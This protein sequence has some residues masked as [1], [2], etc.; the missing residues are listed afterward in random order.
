[1][2]LAQIAFALRFFNMTEDEEAAQI[3]APYGCREG[4]RSIPKPVRVTD[5]L[6]IFEDGSSFARLF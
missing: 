3:P 6:E 2:N 4:F 5:S 1:M